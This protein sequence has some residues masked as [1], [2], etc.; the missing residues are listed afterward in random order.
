MASVGAVDFSPFN[1][2]FTLKVSKGEGMVFICSS[3]A[4]K[5][6]LLITAAHCL[7]GATK[8]IV[9]DG[10]IDRVAYQWEFHPEYNKGESKYKADIGI[11][12]LSRNLPFN[13]NYPKWVRPYKGL[14][15][16]R[17]GFGAREGNN[18][19]TLINGIKILKVKETTLVLQD[20]LG[21]PGD[22]G[23]PIY[24][25]INGRYVLV[26]IHSTV[27]GEHSYAPIIS[28]LLRP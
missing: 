24:Q 15:L 23:G 18:L 22:S 28:D 6:H 25:M 11:V 21:V 8:I 12:T 4:V 17:I 20:K 26:A 10:K 7:E 13:L 3:V 14:P 5:P 27:E 19:R 1:T 16:V 9:T 2:T